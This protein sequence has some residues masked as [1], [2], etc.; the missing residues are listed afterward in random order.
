MGFISAALSSAHGTWKDAKFKEV[1]TIPNYIS[2]D[3]VAIKGEVLTQNP[4]GTEVTNN[5][6][7]GLISD[8]SLVIIPQGY[9]ALAINNGQF[10]TDIAIEPGEYIWDSEKHPTL[11]FD[12]DGFF[13]SAIKNVK[14]VFDRLSKGGQ[15]SDQQE[16][17]FI[18]T[19]PMIGVGFGTSSPVEFMSPTYRNLAIR[20]YGEC[21]IFVHDPL[22]FF[23]HVVSRKI[24]TQ[25]KQYSF[26]EILDKIKKQLPPTIGVA[27]SKYA[28]E[29]KMEIHGMN[30]QMEAVSNATAVNITNDWTVRYGLGI[31][32]LTIMD[33][34]YDEESKAIIKEYDA[35][36]RDR[37]FMDL[38]R[39]RAQNEAMVA[40]AKN[41]AKGA[42][43]NAMMGM[44]MMP[45]MMGM[46]QDAFKQTTPSEPSEQVSNTGTLTS[47]ESAPT[48]SAPTLVQPVV[49][50]LQQDDPLGL[51]DEE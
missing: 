36:A 49:M 39:M 22:R 42:N 2:D 10:I 40:M 6:T 4:D 15:I 46:V 45:Q 38:E 21:D 19:Q 33:V 13:K 1:I 25:T 44:A 23:I 8:G 47:A 27:F 20:F 14:D 5:K 17:V 41:E 37:E 12:K 32:K 51:L 35:K 11:F 18:K 34:S 48:P 3:I 24:N 43:M 7:T 16:I 50:Q 26:N 30:M 29:T 28:Y 9:V 31:S